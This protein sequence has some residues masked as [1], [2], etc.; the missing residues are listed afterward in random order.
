MSI[1]IVSGVKIEE[2]LKL[3]FVESFS[4]NLY[5]YT[6]NGTLSELVNKNEITLLTN[7]KNNIISE[8]NNL[9]C[10]NK[11]ELFYNL[12]KNKYI[13]LNNYDINKIVNV[14]EPISEATL[15]IYKFFNTIEDIFK[16]THNNIIKSEKYLNIY[17]EQYSIASILN[18][19]HVDYL[20]KIYI[21]DLKN[22]SKNIS[23]INDLDFINDIVSKFIKNTL[24]D[25]LIDNKISKYYL[26]HISSK[27]LCKNDYIN[28][29]NDLILIEYKKYLNNK[30][31]YINNLITNIN[32]KIVKNSL[33]NDNIN[34]INNKLKDVI[35][36]NLKIKNINKLLNNNQNLQERLD[37]ISNLLNNNNNLNTSY[38]FDN[39][40]S[41][42]KIIDHSNL[43]FNLNT[44]DF[45]KYET[46]SKYISKYEDFVVYFNN[47]FK[48]HDEINIELNKENNKF[49]NEKNKQIIKDDFINKNKKLL[50]LNI[51]LIFKELL[52]NIYSE[53]SNNLYNN[54][55]LSISEISKQIENFYGNNI[56]ENKDN[57][58]TSIND[59]FIT[60][61]SIIDDHDYLNSSDNN[62]YILFKKYLHYEND[63][64]IFEKIVDENIQILLNEKNNL[65]IDIE[66]QINK[67]LPF[68]C[69]QKN[70]VNIGKKYK[71]NE[72]HKSLENNN[73]PFYYF[74]YE[75]KTIK[76][77]GKILNSENKLISTL[78]DAEKKVITGVQFF[79]IN[80]NIISKSRIKYLESFNN[81]NFNDEHILHKN[82]D[83]YYV[84]NIPYSIYQLQNTPFDT[85]FWELGHIKDIVSI[86]ID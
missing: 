53:L 57:V 46:Y 65:I 14:F 48:T 85:I 11:Q 36:S 60:L 68:K 24:N 71:D 29:V 43:N 80:L 47:I 26:D 74:T 49:L 28:I 67:L 17:Y 3:N 10:K 76:K 51:D 56:I 62:D 31:T 18:E 16:I 39:I 81:I 58:M 21:N 12:F 79:T 30:K 42:N 54:I 86:N 77:L 6:F 50:Y 23:T 72:Y 40:D 84:Y 2:L 34:S 82:I 25:E 32:D 4:D 78:I 22:L 27:K 70:V 45:N 41:I 33:I 69:I 1:N 63:Y 61:K 7:K 5:H 64:Y 52:N 59:I 73:D 55:M 37:I 19:I 75:T 66:N 38:L 13:N 9:I 8:Y 35:D 44:A 83:E 20:N 15:N